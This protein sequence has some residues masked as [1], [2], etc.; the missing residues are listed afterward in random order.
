MLER[1]ELERV[2]A[3][4]RS[5]AHR[6][7]IAQD[8]ADPG[9][10]ALVRLDE[11]RMVM[12]FDFENCRPAVADINRAGILARPLHHQLALRRQLSQMDARRLVRAM[13]RPHHRKNAELCVSRRA[14][15][16]LFDFVVLVGRKSERAGLLDIG[17]RLDRKRNR[18]L[19][20]RTLPSIDWKIL[21]PSSPPSIGSTACSG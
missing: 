5:R 8:S 2:H 10:R 9:R 17:F 21:S 11:R 6:E 4:Y 14:P 15:E 12:A 18:T 20:H 13:L 19:A 3:R 1:S 16:D 7:N